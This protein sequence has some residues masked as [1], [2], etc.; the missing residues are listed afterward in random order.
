MCCVSGG[1][2]SHPSTAHD[3]ASAKT[4]GVLQNPGSVL[5]HGEGALPSCLPFSCVTSRGLS[6]APTAV[7]FE[8]LR[9]FVTRSAAGHTCRKDASETLDA[10]LRVT[11][12]RFMEPLHLSAAERWERPAMKTVTDTRTMHDVE[13]HWPAGSPLA[14]RV[15]CACRGSQHLSTWP[16]RRRSEHP[17]TWH[18]DQKKKLMGT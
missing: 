15:W 8:S 3:L 10:I 17:R 4:P 1:S 13:E 7:T 16:S 14:H 5:Q 11:F 18:H 6:V 2:V 12:L 9:L